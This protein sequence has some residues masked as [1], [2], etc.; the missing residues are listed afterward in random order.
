MS[1]KVAAGMRRDVTFTDTPTSYAREP[2][3][4]Q[5]PLDH[6]PYRSTVLRHPKQPLVYLPQ[7]ITELTGSQLDPDRP[8]DEPDSDLTHQHEGEPIGERI[9][10]S[11]RVLDT[12]GMPLRETLVE[13]W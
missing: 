11:G 1:T 5:P 3:D 4:A 13:V 2:A 7:T 10:L 12:D 8:I 6:P 9:T